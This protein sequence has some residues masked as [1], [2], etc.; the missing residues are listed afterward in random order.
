MK[1]GGKKFYFW[2]V[3]TQRGEL[4]PELVS[5]QKECEVRRQIYE[6]LQKTFKERILVTP[7]KEGSS[8]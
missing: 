1:R 3:G 5:I 4:V 8:G 2:A 7:E 6:N